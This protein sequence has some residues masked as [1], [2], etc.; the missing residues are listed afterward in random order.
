MRR[1]AIVLLGLAVAV[2]LV[3]CRG[4]R[5]PAPQM[6]RAPGQ[7]QIVTI[8]AW[9]GGNPQ[10]E[11]GRIGMLEKAAERLNAQLEREGSN[12]R[13]RVEGILDTSGDMA[14]KFVL[15]AQAGQAPDIVNSSHADIAAWAQAG[16]IVPLD[17]YIAKYRD[18]T[19]LKDIIP[20]LWEPMRFRGA[21]WGVPQ[22]TEAR[23]LYFS[24]PLLR[25]LGWSESD[26]EALPDRIRNGQFTLYDMLRVAKEAQDRG[27]VRPG[28][29]YWTRPVFGDNYW[30]GD[31]YQ[32][33]VAFGGSLWDPQSGRLTVDR[34]ALR[35]F[36]QF[37]HDAIFGYGVTARTVIGGTEWKQWHETVSRGDQVLF[38]NGGVWQWAEWAQGYL[39][40]DEGRL[41]DNVGFALIPAGEPGRRPTTLSHPLAYMVTSEKAS[42]RRNQELAFRLIALATSPDLNSEYAV[43]SKHLAILRTQL[44]DPTYTR[45]RF[46]AATSYMVEHAFFLPNN[47][48]YGRFDATLGRVLLALAA[49]QLNVDQAVERA[50]ADLQSAV[51]ELVVR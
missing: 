12:V 35:K 22:D 15:A 11:R 48:D 5:E 41:W 21:T 37:H 14:R 16:F 49:G 51:P 43:Q 32:F 7:V 47:P 45:D 18:S 26:I 31:F 36:F 34:E 24:K 1:I 33:Y 9:A 27:V 13:V 17:Q 2:L 50:I 40:G 38:W 30:G 46:L 28:Y 6:Q 42:G 8:T 29:G 3:A 23:P 20:N 10:T 44:N 39:G 19:D 4:G 25:R